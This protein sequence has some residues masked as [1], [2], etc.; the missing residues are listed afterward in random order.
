[1]HAGRCARRRVKTVSNEHTETQ[2]ER[3][4]ALAAPPVHL[5]RPG[6]RALTPNGVLQLQ[7][8]LGNRA[9]GLMM[10]ARQGSHNRTGLP[11]DLKS[12]VESLS[13]VSLEGVRVR[14]NSQD[15]ARL[16]AR[17]FTRGAEIH[18]A[19]G[20]ERH[21]PH[22]AW[23]VVQQAQGRVPANAQLKGVALNEDHALESEADL[24]GARALQA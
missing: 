6:A 11:D 9:V 22:E 19:P 8:T 5:A 24:M 13:G 7:R 20:E 21:L 12:G 23:H 16:H 14:S 3:A 10:K 1:M 17:A 2:K 15:P 18:A 4:H